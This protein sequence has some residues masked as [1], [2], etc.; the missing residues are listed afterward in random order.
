MMAFVAGS[1]GYNHAD[2]GERQQHDRRPGCQLH[3]VLV[4]EARLLVDSIGSGT[5]MVALIA[6][7]SRKPSDT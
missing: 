4:H 2:R 5:S 1:S 6:V 3:R 7:P